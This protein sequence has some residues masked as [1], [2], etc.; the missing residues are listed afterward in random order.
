MTSKLCEATLLLSASFLL[1]TGC[2]DS[3]ESEKQTNSNQST[4]PQITETS[5]LLKGLKSLTL[6][7]DKTTL[8]KDEKTSVKVMAN[9]DDG[10][11]KDL[12][13]KV[14]WIICPQE[15]VDVN[16][17]VLTAKKDGN[18]TVQAKVGT[19]LSNTLNL[20]IAWVV[21]GH[22]LPH[23]PDPT[24]NNS[25][26]LGIDSNDN[27]VR[28]DVERY[29]YERFGK[30]PEYPKTKIALAMQDA[31][32]T[33]KILETPTIE[34]KKYLDDAIDCQYYW[35]DKKTQGLS[36][37]EFIQYSV[38]HKVFDDIN[39]K[40]KMLNTKQRILRKFKF[41]EACSGHIFRGR[42]RGRGRGKETID[43][44]QTNIDMLGE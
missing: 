14:E 10:T 44:C 8:N 37:Y 36:G 17:T 26:L 24:V 34:S 31:W 22:V 25:T 39:L 28:D 19:T 20:T 40:D 43:S 6:S 7:V 21:N 1:F 29:I 11:T 41:N 27:G 38:K 18:V 4:P 13:G 15:S 5:E 2:G 3:S 12:T 33:Q 35:F 9:Y 42:G 32:S 16:G 30:D 23:E